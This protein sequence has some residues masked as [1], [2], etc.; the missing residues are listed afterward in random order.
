M[1][2]EYAI[3]VYSFIAEYPGMDPKEREALFVILKAAKKQIPKKPHKDV[4]GKNHC[5][6][7]PCYDFGTSYRPKYC[8]KCGQALDWSDVE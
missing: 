3:N 2:L 6:M 7:W 1:E 4:W 8:P 5:P